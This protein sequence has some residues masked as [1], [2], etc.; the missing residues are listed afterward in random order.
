MKKKEKEH[1]IL[2]R[3]IAM[4]LVVSLL[5]STLPASVL[6]AGGERLQAAVKTLEENAAPG[7][8]V[9]PEPQ[10][11]PDTTE[12]ETP[13]PETAEPETPEAETTEPETAV[14]EPTQPTPEAQAKEAEAKTPEA[15][16]AP[17]GEIMSV[18]N[19]LTVAESPQTQDAKIG[20]SVVLAAK[21]EAQNPDGVTYQWQCKEGGDPGIEV[22]STDEALER[23][24]N[25]LAMAESIDLTGITGD[26]S[27]EA[28]KAVQEKENAI[29][30]AKTRPIQPDNE[31]WTDIPGAN[32]TQL[33]VTLDSETAGAPLSYRL[34]TRTADAAIATPAA[35]VRTNSDFAGGTGTQRDPYIIATDEQLANLHKYEGTASQGKYWRLRPKQGKYL[36]TDLVPI[37][38]QTKPFMG[39]LDGDG[40]YISSNAPG[41][42]D[43]RQTKYVPIPA[44]NKNGTEVTAYGC[45]L[46]GFLEDATIVNLNMV[47]MTSENT[48]VEKIPGTNV[49]IAAG[50]HMAA[51][52]ENATI[53]NCYTYG[54][55]EVSNNFLSGEYQI[56]FLWW[57]EKINVYRYA[58]CGGM[59]ACGEVGD[60]YTVR[61]TG[62]LANTH[63][64]PNMFCTGGN[65]IKNFA[66]TGTVYPNTSLSKDYR[67]EFVKNVCSSKVVAID[68][69]IFF[70]FNKITPGSIEMPWL[71][72][73]HDL[74]NLNDY[75][76]KDETGILNYWNSEGRLI[77]EIS[78]RGVLDFTVN[79][80]IKTYDG[81]AQKAIVN[82]AWKETE[83]GRDWDYSYKNDKGETVA[84]DSVKLPGTY[85]IDF[86]E[87]NRDYHLGQVVSQ[88]TQSQTQTTPA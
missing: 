81:S 25:D 21:I 14:F 74:A 12:P 82:C 84:E 87:I 39:T 57:K 66:Q 16:P 88:P 67:P 73:N 19:A 43:A 41:T 6:A 31:G 53:M 23:K 9:T 38:N 60:G 8:E 32:D 7:P 72:W 13:E 85:L 4:L 71:D 2:K 18:S 28:A 56:P 79:D 10:E 17:E 27:E 45:A 37:G 15:D 40:Y 46:F 35:M 83:R 24:Q 65:T 86:E 51:A 52:G 64:A 34:V 76:A 78:T 61:F 42:S 63:N 54:R 1:T 26:E 75:V 47:C 33:A 58:L 68:M 20:E 22:Q 77:P 50:A 55:D 30:E 11:E 44:Y 80:Y 70:D 3:V 36:Y 48:S 29:R 69:G 62:K 59:V 5:L 49:A